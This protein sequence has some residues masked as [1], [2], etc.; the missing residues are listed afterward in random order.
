MITILFNTETNKPISNYLSGGY[1]VDGKPQSVELPIIELEVIKTARPEILDTQKIS[2]EWV[3]DLEAKQYVL[4]WYVEDKTEEELFQEYNPT[5]TQRLMELNEEPPHREDVLIL[6]GTQTQVR[7]NFEISGITEISGTMDTIFTYEYINIATPINKDNLISSI[8]RKRYSQ[9]QSEYILRRRMVGHGS[10][11][12]LKFNNY[13]Q[14]AMV[15]GNNQD[16]SEYINKTVYE[17]ILPLDQCV[18]SGDYAGMAFEV[19]V[20]HITF[21]ADP[22]AN[23]GKA[24]P[25]WIDENVLPYLV[26]DP[27]VTVNTVQ[28]WDS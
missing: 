1:K 9:D 17:V 25:G 23:T 24:Y 16:P 19:I 8:I 4:T 27:R 15:I 26:G 20:K 6:G 13:A 7:Y 2:S 12:Y 21:E 11:N 28:L 3:A 5:E 14:Y 10:L 22:I 18:G